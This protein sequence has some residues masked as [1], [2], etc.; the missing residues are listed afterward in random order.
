[1]LPLRAH[2][3]F[4]DFFGSKW[5]SLD[6]DIRP[7]FKNKLSR[8][9]DNLMIDENEEN[10]IKNGESI[11]TSSVYTKKNGEESKKTVTSKKTYKDGKAQ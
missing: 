7:Q 10:N 11:R 9:L 3:I 4:D 6:D 2:S 5:M 1:M 8:N